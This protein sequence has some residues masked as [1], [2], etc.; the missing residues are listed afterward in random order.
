MIT[1]ELYR[2]ALNIIKKY[3]DEHDALKNAKRITIEQFNEMIPWISSNDSS[4][5]TIRLKNVLKEISDYPRYCLQKADKYPKDK[6]YYINQAKYA[7][8]YIDELD[9][10][11]LKQ[12]RNTGI[13]TIK[14]FFEYKISILNGN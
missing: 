2:E 10:I 8:K 13:K 12:Q 5:S 7:K 6:E 3:N 1:D 4:K 11:V 14:Q 9:E